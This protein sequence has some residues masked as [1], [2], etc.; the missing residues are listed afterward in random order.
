M[1]PENSSVNEA[2]F[3]S[4]LPACDMTGVSTS[5]TPRRA[6][7]SRTAALSRARRRSAANDAVGCQA[8]T[9]GVPCAAAGLP[10]RRVGR[11]VEAAMAAIGSDR[12]RGHGRPRRS[13][14]LREERQQAG[15]VPDLDAE[16]L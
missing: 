1:R 12:N 6:K 7:N 14:V 10:A 4:V 13:F 9:R 3:G 8:V 15:L 11:P 2:M 5:S 16:F